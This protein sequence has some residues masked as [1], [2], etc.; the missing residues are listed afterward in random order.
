MLVISLSCLLVHLVV[1]RNKESECIAEFD[2]IA[3]SVCLFSKLLASDRW[4]DRTHRCQWLQDV[5]T[6]ERTESPEK[7]FGKRA[8]TLGPR[9]MLGWGGLNAIA[10][11]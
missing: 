4:G 2:M 11:T 5:V 6:T 7:A 3:L 9:N 1:S 10:S 8:Q